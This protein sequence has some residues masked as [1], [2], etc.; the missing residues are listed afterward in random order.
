[1]GGGSPKMDQIGL[2]ELEDRIMAHQTAWV[3]RH[4]GEAAAH[5]ANMGWGVEERGTEVIIS[6]KFYGYG[7]LTTRSS[8]G[9]KFF[10]QWEEFLH[11]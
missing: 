7:I 3:H 8:D 2:E 9:N 6:S 10:D 1:M 5:N 11:D 4:F